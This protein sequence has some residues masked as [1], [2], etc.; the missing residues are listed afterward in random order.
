MPMGPHFLWQLMDSNLF[1]PV[2]GTPAIGTVSIH[3]PDT[4]GN[5]LTEIGVAILPVERPL[6]RSRVPACASPARRLASQRGLL[7]GRRGRDLRREPG[8][9]PARPVR[10]AVER[11]RLPGNAPIRVGESGADVGRRDHQ[12]RARAVADDCSPRHG[13]VLR[14]FT[15][16]TDVPSNFALYGTTASFSQTASPK[17]TSQYAYR[18]RVTQADFDSPISGTPVPY[19]S[20]VGAITQRIFVGDQDGTI[21][22]P[23]SATRTRT[24]GSSSRSSTPTTPRCSRARRPPLWRTEPPSCS[25]PRC[26]SG[27]TA[28]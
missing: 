20:D 11:Q 12:P 6:R 27:A 17:L 23:T 26:R 28:T 19:P 25:P 8:R 16:L 3:D 15:V 21:G 4:T 24:T 13:E 2:G 10:P 1:A 7:H 5:P 14:T 18:G 9:L 22:E